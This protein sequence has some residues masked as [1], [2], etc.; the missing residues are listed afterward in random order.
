MPGVW[1]TTLI[2]TENFFFWKFTLL[3]EYHLECL[4]ETISTS[5]PCK[6]S[7]V[8]ERVTVKERQISTHRFNKLRDFWNNF[9]HLKL[10][11]YFSMFWRWPLLTTFCCQRLPEKLASLLYESFL[12]AFRFRK[13]LFF[14]VLEI[15]KKKCPVWSTSEFSGICHCHRDLAKGLMLRLYLHILK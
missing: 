14:E 5:L 12:R 10:I 8:G 13:D 2:P 7:W 11:L 15:I 1:G 6:Y 9:L 3:K 4:G